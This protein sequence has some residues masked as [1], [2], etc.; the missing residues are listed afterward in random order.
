MAFVHLHNH[1][2]YSL[3]SGAIRIPDMVEKAALEG[4]S[5]LALTDYGNIFGAV[6]F[7]LEAKKKGVKPIIGAVVFHPS[8]DNH[9]DRT[10]RRGIDQL[11]QL[12]LLVENEIGYKNLSRLLTKSYLDGFYYKP[13][14]DSALLREH[15]QG[16]IALSGGWDGAINQNLFNQ[17]SKEA[18]EYLDLYASIFPDRFYI[19]LQENDIEGQHELNLELIRIAKE[20]NIPYIAT[21]DC[22][23]LTPDDAEAFETMLCI[24][25]G[26]TLHGV[27]SEIKFAGDGHSFKS[28]E[29]MMDS[30][31]YAPEALERTQEV[32]DRCN[33]EFDLETY[34]FPRFDPPEGKTLDQF[35]EEEAYKGLEQRWPRIL[36][37]RQ[38]NSENK[39]AL[40]KLKNEYKDRI[41][42][43]LGVIQSMGFSGYFLIVA[44]FIQY[45]KNHAIPVGPGRGSAAGSLVAYCVQITDID[46]L[47]YNLLFER[48][49]NPE[50]ISMPDVDVDFCME[51]RQKVIEYVAEK[52][53][54]VS[55]IIT[56]G[57]MK[58]KAVIRDVGRVMEMP[59]EEVDK[60]A[61][62]IP[63]SLN[64]TLSEAME[65]EPRLKDLMKENPQVNRLMETALRLEG[66][67]R[68][69]STH[70]AGVVMSDQPLSDFLPLYQGGAQGDIVTQFDMKFVEKIGLIKF[71]FLG[72]KT[73]TI[74]DRAVK[75]I[76]R[77]KGAVLNMLEIPLDDMS[78]YDQLTKGDTA[79]VF[80]LES[81]G[82]KDLLGRLKPNCFE[83][84][85]ALV[86]LYR[87]GPLGSG[88]VDDFVDR[89]HGR[90]KIVYDLP[91]L[92]PILEDTYGVIV[93]QEQVMQIASALGGYSLGEADLL[94]R[95]MGKKKA[96]EM[97]AQRVRFL[98]GAKALSIDPS[99]A[100]KIFDLMA[101]FAEYG[102]NKSHS[103][104]Y[105]FVSYQTAFLKTHY[106][107]EYL[108]SILSIEMH[109]TDRVLYYFQDCDQHK[110][111]VLGP[112]INESF[113]E[114]RV[115]GEDKIRY[116]LGALKNVGRGAIDAI[117]EARQGEG[118]QFESFFHFTK[119]IDYSRVNKRVIEA[120]VKSGAFDQLHSNRAQLFDAIED[121][122][123]VA[124]RSQKDA[125]QG[126]TNLFAL[127]ESREDSPSGVEFSKDSEWSDHE[128]LQ[129][130][131][132]A[133]GFY[134]S[135]HPL[136]SFRASIDKITEMNTFLCQNA[137]HEEEIT[138]VGMIQT[139]KIIT[140]KKGKRM[141]FLNFEDLK[142]V[143]EV[144]VFPDVFK[145]TV[146]LFGC[147][148]PLVLRGTIDRTEE[149]TKIL[150]TEI[151]LLADIFRNRTKSVHIKLRSE[152]VS[153]AYMKRL[154]EVL[155]GFKGDCQGYLHIIS[156]GESETILELSEGL[157]LSDQTRLSLMV[158][159]VFKDKVVEYGV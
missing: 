54:N 130:E 148:E 49:L 143:I 48:F 141:A 34:H 154:Y 87:P 147:D 127:M 35:L 47:P 116:G 132:D 2:E 39:E 40:E 56:F 150:A 8:H 73:L 33:F 86:A 66:L 60:I 96:E 21:N 118:G 92:E 77:T 158:N 12:V 91:Q 114:F 45:A 64:I 113:F 151:K 43:E 85:V 30:F 128:K 157:D 110:I 117:V 94:R 95:A 153:E 102:F 155:E 1:S 26:A 20:K 108:A 38:L 79:G 139:S 50:R 142:G 93:Y 70:A 23:Y 4:M 107:V 159:R 31:S 16:L 15:A 17:K 5:A 124:I 36:V 63:N 51:G 122:M 89:K 80:Q 105:A 134:F 29:E 18:M 136:E 84:L 10:F 137:R 24:Q 14:I 119:V 3:L 13:R 76:K 75:T 82:M 88:M 25:T 27:N 140:T 156:P 106:P 58:A 97:A 98:D 101:K 44:D 146:D 74:I 37:N 123:N 120:L 115:V 83:D 90:T 144:I 22:H 112:D 103:A 78:V 131:K 62:L 81:T 42:I 67:N 100:E 9:K 65:E 71:D 104:A 149:G 19:E 99:L 46:P 111:K 69:A 72:L 11:Y 135:G 59:Y 126:Q 152:L 52:F 121:S 68:H 7:F 61:K 28:T 133:M 41:K 109:N 138:L 125:G 32:S 145:D 55:Q 6:D 57:K 129:Y 53:G